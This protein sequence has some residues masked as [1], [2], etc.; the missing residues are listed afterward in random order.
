MD[1]TALQTAILAEITTY[2]GVALALL[3][4]SLTL[5]IGIKLV[6]KVFGKSV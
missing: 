3:T 6:K 2:G 4:A 1:V 5:F